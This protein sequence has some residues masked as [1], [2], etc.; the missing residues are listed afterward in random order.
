MQF[1][2]VS[3][4][5]LKTPGP[6]LLQ[7]TLCERFGP[8]PMLAAI[9]KQKRQKT[10][11]YSSEEKLEKV[12][13]RRQSANAKE[14][15]RIRNLNRGFSKLKMLVPLI[16]RDRKPSKVDTLKAATEYIRLLHDIL[17]DAEEMELNYSADFNS[18]GNGALPISLINDLSGSVIQPSSSVHIK[19]EEDIEARPMVSESE[20]PAYIQ[21]GNVP[22]YLSVV[23][24]QDGTL[25]TQN[26]TKSN[27]DS[28]EFYRALEFCCN[29]RLFEELNC[30]KKKLLADLLDAKVQGV[31]VRSR[32]QSLSQM[33]DPTQYFFGKEKKKAQHKLIHC[34]KTPTAEELCEPA[35]IQR[36]AVAFYSDLFVVEA[37]DESEEVRWF[38]EGL[39]QVPEEENTQ[40]ESPLT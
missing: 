27:W 23:H 32:F 20:M 14:R 24:L 1:G 8:L 19:E 7:D 33:D 13:E 5:L 25:Y 15:E 9:R 18:T 39:T 38:L 3:I 12:F 10:G 2:E 37:V 31:L 11:E 21:S 17:E 22:A 6:E 30:K 35:E 29:I 28:Q 40:L 4:S 36:F 34:V 26:I 16:P